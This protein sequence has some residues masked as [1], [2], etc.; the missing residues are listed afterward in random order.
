LGI[1]SYLILFFASAALSL[2]L[3]RLVRN[4]AITHGWVQTPNLD[5][6]VHLKPIPR[7]G[8]VA[9][10]LSVLAAALCGLFVPK[11]IG[12]AQVSPTRGAFGLLAPATLIFLLGI[13]DDIRPVNAYLKFGV[14]A[15]AG[16]ILYFGGQ[17]IQQFHL[18]SNGPLRIGVALPLTV[19]WV[20]LIT[21][22]FNLIDGLDGLAAGSAFFST[23]VLC[24]VSLFGSIPLVIFLT[25]ALAGAILG[26]MRYNFYP[27]SIFMGDSGSLFIGFLLSALALSG[28]QKAS[29]MIAVAIPVL[30]FGLP[31]LDVALAVIR[32]FLRGQ[33]LF[34]ADG[35]H[36]H[37]RLLKKGLSQRQAVSILYAASAGFGLLSL[38]LL[39]DQKNITL[40]LAIMGIGVWV[41]VQ[42]LRYVEASEL[43]DFLHRTYQKKRML[44]NNLNI[45]RGIESLNFCNDFRGICKVLEETLQPVGFDGVLFKAFRG[46]GISD[47]HFYPLKRDKD[48]IWFCFWKGRQTAKSSWELKLELASGPRNTR[49]GYFS[50]LRSCED[51]ALFLV[52]LNL[53]SSQFRVAVSD[54]VLRAM[55]KVE[56][57]LK[58][59]IHI[60]KQLPMKAIPARMSSA[61]A[62]HRHPMNRKAV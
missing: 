22:A 59:S 15:L 31:I 19:L 52:D 20:L 57:N 40:V 41:G 3:T 14:Q 60:K 23:L 50:L 61:D 25:I 38:A 47:V 51:E 44:A 11:L 48:G 18:L 34:S 28:L 30:C 5:R 53:L 29:M 37:H 6:H 43:Q 9:I 7:L 45:R 8:G 55:S 54:A 49:G 56:I 1:Y 26:F 2:V 36:I 58:N 10:Y 13:C 21:N 12:V 4:F 16:V 35:E 27:A 33:P 39:H 42:Q 32:R 46:D 17:G 24:V 62:A